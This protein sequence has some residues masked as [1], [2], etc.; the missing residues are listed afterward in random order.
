MDLGPVSAQGK[1][2]GREA[3]AINPVDAKLRG[4][5]DGDVIRVFNARGACLAGAVITAQVRRG[6]VQLS[7]GAWY[8]PADQSPDALCA[9]GNPNVLT[10]DRGTSRLGQGPSSA[11]ALVEIERMSGAVPPVRA[12][13]PPPLVEGES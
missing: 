6:V 2:G 1:I 11:T 3:I 12:F 7:C 5:Q 10:Y 9:H 13:V 4:I 8:D